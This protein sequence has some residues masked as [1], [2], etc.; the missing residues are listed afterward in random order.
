MEE[1][2]MRDTM[3]SDYGIEKADKRVELNDTMT[4]KET[5]I[6]DYT[7]TIKNIGGGSNE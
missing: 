1:N 4:I 6:D 3:V 5:P 2:K 7:K